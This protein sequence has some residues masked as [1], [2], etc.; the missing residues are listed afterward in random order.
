MECEPVSQRGQ[1]NPIVDVVVAVKFFHLCSAKLL[2]NV[3]QRFLDEDGLAFKS[4]DCIRRRE[5]VLLEPVY[6]CISIKDRPNYS[7]RD[8][9]YSAAPFLKNTSVNFGF[10]GNTFSLSSRQI[11]RLGR[12]ALSFKL[13]RSKYTSS[14]TF[15]HVSG[16]PPNLSGLLH[17]IYNSSCCGGKHDDAGRFSLELVKSLVH[18]FEMPR[19]P[20]Q[21][22]VFDKLFGA[23]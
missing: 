15:G 16:L 23:I 19:G 5:G 14:I 20:D 1:W 2:F 21:G 3:F 7:S 8:C 12:F 6:Q 11:P 18:R 13:W 17:T 10:Q 22:L 4:C 9:E